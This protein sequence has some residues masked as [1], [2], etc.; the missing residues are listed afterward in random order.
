MPFDSFDDLDK[1]KPQKWYNKLF[2]Q[3]NTPIDEL[4]N[5]ENKKI[6]D[7]FAQPG[8]NDSP[9]KAASKGFVSGAISGV[10][11]NWLS[12]V[13]TA[14]ALNKERLAEQALS[15]AAGISGNFAL[16]GSKAAKAAGMTKD[17]IEAV[18]AGVKPTGLSS[19][20]PSSKAA[21]VL[22]NAPMAAEQ[23]YEAKE[24]PTTLGKISHGALAAGAGAAALAEG[25]GA[26]RGARSAGQAAAGVAGSKA[27]L[28]KDQYD[29]FKAA[30]LD[31]KNQLSLEGLYQK[32][33]LVKEEF[34]KNT[35]GNLAKDF[36]G[37]NGRPAPLTPA[38]QLAQKGPAAGKVD[39]AQGAAQTLL[40]KERQQQ[41]KSIQDA[42]KRAK[43]NQV[44]VQSTEGKAEKAVIDQYNRAKKNQV[45]VQNAITKGQNDLVGQ[46]NAEAMQNKIDELMVGKEQKDPTSL[47]ES[48]QGEGDFGGKKRATIRYVTPEEDKEPGSISPEEEAALGLGDGPKTP[49]SSGKL[50]ATAADKA[51]ARTRPFGKLQSYEQDALIPT[52]R[53]ALKDAKAAGVDVNSD[54]LADQ[55]ATELNNAKDQ[56]SWGKDST[57]GADDFLKAARS[58]KPK[59]K[60]LDD[61]SEEIAGFKQRMRKAGYTNVGSMFTKD[62]GV[63][64]PIDKYA[65]GLKGTT[66]WE[67]FENPT[68]YSLL[69]HIENRANTNGVMQQKGL[70]QMVADQ[71][72]GTDW[73]KPSVPEEPPQNEVPVHDVQPS[74]VSEEAPQAPSEDSEVGV[75]QDADTS[76]NPEDLEPPTA[77]AP[78]VPVKPRSP[79]GGAGGVANF[80]NRV[81]SILSGVGAVTPEQQALAQST[82]AASQ[83]PAETVPEFAGR[84]DQV[85]TANPVATLPEQGLNL[86]PPPIA[87]A[88]TGI[89][90]GMAAAKKVRGGVRSAK[91]S[92]TQ[93]GADLLDKLDE[94]TGTPAPT[95]KMTPAQQ[96]IVDAQRAQTA[97]EE[98][99]KG[100]TVPVAPTEPTTGPS[101]YQQALTAAGESYGAL[102][103]A[104]RAGESIDEETRQ[105]AAFKAMEAT[106]EY[107]QAVVDGKIHPGEVDQLPKIYQGPVRSAIKAIVKKF[108]SEGGGG[109][110]GSETGAAKLGPI[111]NLG[112]GAAGAIGGA[113]YD[114][115]NPTRGA[116]LGGLAGL[117]AP[118]AIG[119][120]ASLIAR[121]A[122]SASEPADK[123][124]DLLN[125]LH[126]TGLLSPLSVIKKG[127]GDIGGLSLA[128]M[129]NPDRAGDILRQFLTQEGRS[130][131]AKAFGSGYM[132]PQ[133]EEATGLENYIQNKW[134][135]LSVSGRTMG[136]LTSATKH[137]L[138]EA[139]IPEA[140]QKYYTLTAEP[141]T[142]L[143]KGLFNV[144]RSS[145]LAQH[146]VPFARIGI[147]R[148]E[149]AYDYS[150]FG[151]IRNPSTGFYKDTAALQDQV[152]KSMLGTT[153]GTGAY[154]LTPDDYVKEHPIQASI[155]SSLAGPLGLTTLAGMAAK[156]AR[157]QEGT[158]GK[159]T[160]AQEAAQEIGRDVPGLR[161]L[162]DIEGRSF[163]IGFL[164]N[165]LSGYTNFA[166]PLALLNSPVDFDPDLSSK[167]LPL[168]QQ[169]A[170][171]SLSNIPGIRETLPEK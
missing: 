168:W 91:L 1:E 2:E 80:N 25:V 162:E 10:T 61:G 135:P 64:V 121:G 41:L 24:S 52:V 126:N 26:V 58:G 35:A 70:A 63:G 119:P 66:G 157:G 109:I 156:T 87:P 54:D 120:M 60:I 160:S 22:G 150:P 57:N 48:I 104:K 92:E 165:Y 132:G 62:K 55:I 95:P 83:A 19:L 145:K 147:N 18:K 74:V 103:D 117:V 166:R 148:L 137:I 7:A 14:G 140:A 88:K 170:N 138:G 32:F 144:T 101:T 79:K 23:A 122:A 17:A 76:F 164:R 136:G 163:P 153:I 141:S 155:L 40:G 97:A 154:A 42:Y 134:N 128:A 27:Q 20:L 45:A 51:L 123:G 115:D 43:T 110:G 82:L 142:K 167:D 143:G 47:S 133:T 4:I 37:K 8:L 129:E 50:V 100:G 36:F 125:K 69:D 108:S 13:L 93:Q 75:P 124:I 139:G 11:P 77:A 98:A 94:E 116:I 56:A 34:D 96:A 89:L 111:M 159:L 59:T 78:V 46:A 151:M 146:L 33:P 85:A 112:M 106:R 30:A 149:R 67:S 12:Q 99:G 21:A 86:T 72:M 73:W 9:L 90:P 49:P 39:K 28:L 152:L 158:L 15:K 3:Y 130:G 16:S 84:L 102:R 127:A 169:I 161:L 171:R 6:M 107:A 29:A 113:N 65:Q 114:E 38:E 44:A 131:I 31:P 118:H 81:Q 68:E 5:P 105:A 71:H 53:Q